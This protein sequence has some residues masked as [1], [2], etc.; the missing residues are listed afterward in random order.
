MMRAVF[1]LFAE[2][3]GMLPTEQLYWDSYAIRGL[4]DDLKQ[5]A[6]AVVPRPVL[7]TRALAGVARAAG[8]LG[9]RSDQVARLS[10]DKIVDNSAACALFGWEPAPLAVRLEQAYLEGSTR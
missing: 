4:L 1:L 9:L 10:E 6:C 3:R 8:M 7:P 2:E 5:L